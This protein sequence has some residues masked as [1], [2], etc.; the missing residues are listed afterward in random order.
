MIAIQK[1]RFE[2]FIERD[3]T[4]MRELR[5]YLLARRNLRR[6]QAE[7][8]SGE[9]AITVRGR[10]QELTALINELTKENTP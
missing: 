5:E 7:N 1:S 6:E 8:A 2:T 3:V 4:V 9:A 10:C